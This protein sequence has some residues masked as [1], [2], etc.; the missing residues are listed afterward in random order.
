VFN[1]RTIKL[2]SVGDLNNLGSP[3]VSHYKAAILNSRSLLKLSAVNHE[4]NS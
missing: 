1:N 2:P 3:L 4:S